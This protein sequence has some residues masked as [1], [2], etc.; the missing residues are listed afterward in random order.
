MLYFD[1]YV[2]E[3]KSGGAWCG[4]FTEQYYEN[5]ERVAPVVGVVTN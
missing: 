4:N 5:G 1:Y 2:R 3:G